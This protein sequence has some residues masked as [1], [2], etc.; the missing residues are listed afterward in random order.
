MSE[1]LLQL[2]QIKKSFK[3]AEKKL[4]VLQ[5]VSLSMKAGQVVALLG[6]SGAGKSTLLHIAGLLEC[7]DHGEVIIEGQKTS[8]LSDRKRTQIRC[9]TIGFVYQFHHLLPE[10][11]ALENVILP[12]LIKGDPQALAK[13]RALALLEQVGLEDRLSHLPSELSGGE[14]QRVAIARALA[15]AP[16]ILLADEPTGNLDTH[17]SQKIFRLILER[18]HKDKLAA[19]IVTHNSELAAQADVVLTMVNGALEGKSNK[20]TIL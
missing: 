12:Q 9:H 17:T 15:N 16:K 20:S 14:Q 1:T 7:P 2:N 5:G 10:F 3:E 19:L 8:Q 4:H 11:T 6:P 18:T 13:E